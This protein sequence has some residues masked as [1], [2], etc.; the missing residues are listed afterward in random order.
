MTT[1]SAINASTT[2]YRSCDGYCGAWSCWSPDATTAQ[3]YL[4]NP[5][6]GGTEIVESV[7]GTD[8]ILDLRGQSDI[9]AR[10]ELASEILRAWNRLR[11]RQD[12]IEDL[13]DA[14]DNCAYL[15]EIWE[16][17]EYTREILPTLYDAIAHDAETYPERATT[18]VRLVD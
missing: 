8:Y 12:V 13:L 2:I 6:F 9:S 4:D 14:W 15:Y 1:L 7:V 3:M 5:G 10:R 11:D 17:C 16:R 18:V